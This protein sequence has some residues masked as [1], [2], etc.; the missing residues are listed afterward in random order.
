MTKKIEFDGLKRQNYAV[1]EGCNSLRTNIRFCGDSLQ[2]LL[3]TSTVS[4]EGKSSL[5]F[6]TARSFAEE[7]SRTLLIDADMRK[8]VIVTQRNIKCDEDIRGL[9]HC[10]SGQ[11]AVEDC[12]Y[13]T[14]VENMD[15]ITA[16]PVTPNPT[17]LLGSA[18]FRE[19][20][21]YAREKYDCVI[22]DGPPLGAVIDAAVVAP[23]ADG[24]VF[25]I[26]DNWVSYRKVQEAVKQIKMT[27]CKVLG[28]VLNKE[29]D[30]K[31]YKKAYKKYK[32]YG[33]YDHYGR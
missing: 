5:S 24:A 2:V 11:A 1:R 29:T 32:K 8:S 15:I 4:E 6:E 14:D 31:Y 23:E 19:L 17:E 30:H 9:S 20:I 33:H 13:S 12:I 28:A 3:I 22:I 27:G 26:R 10:L 16:G 18:N 7:G 25:V 21:A